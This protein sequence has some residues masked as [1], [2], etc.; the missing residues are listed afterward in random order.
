MA[1][2]TALQRDWSSHLQAFVSWVFALQSTMICTE[3]SV[4][5]SSVSWSLCLYLLWK[6]TRGK[7]R[8]TLKCSEQ[9]SSLIVCNVTALQRD[10]CSHLQTFVSL[11]HCTS[12]STFPSFP[13]ATNHHATN[14]PVTPTP[15]PS[16][17]FRPLHLV[18]L[19][20]TTILCSTNSFLPWS[21]PSKPP[22]PSSALSITYPTTSSPNVHQS[23]RVISALARQAMA[24]LNQKLNEL[25]CMVSFSA[26]LKRSCFSCHA[27]PLTSRDDSSYQVIFLDGDNMLPSETW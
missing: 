8:E 11:L 13:P 20:N 12:P 17:L 19:P 1:L 2:D 21:L 22:S 4:H 3:K 23:H 9:N 10:W 5:A 24:V 26:P 7:H 18:S 14:P 27:L 16:L 25:C 15:I 6:L